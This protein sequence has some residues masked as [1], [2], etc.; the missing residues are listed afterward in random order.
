VRAQTPHTEPC[1]RLV[2]EVSSPMPPL[3]AG[4]TLPRH[5]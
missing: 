1:D 3:P 5:S 2:T 4:G